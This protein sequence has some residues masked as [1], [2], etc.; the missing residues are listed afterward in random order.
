MTD[1]RITSCR[2]VWVA[3]MMY[4]HDED[5]AGCAAAR[6][7]ECERCELTVGPDTPADVIDALI[8]AA[9]NR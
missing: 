3:G 2:H 9:H 8:D 6:T 7:V 4:V 5:L 1:T